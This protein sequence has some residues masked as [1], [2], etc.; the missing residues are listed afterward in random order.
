MPSKNALNLFAK[1]K[2]KKRKVKAQEWE[3]NLNLPNELIGTFNN[4]EE[5]FDF[6]KT[7]DPRYDEIEE[8][9]HGGKTHK[10]KIRQITKE[11]KDNWDY[12]LPYDYEIDIDDVIKRHGI[13]PDISTKR[14]WKR[15]KY[16]ASEMNIYLKKKKKYLAYKKKKDE[17][18]FRNKVS[19]MIL[20]YDIRLFINIDDVIDE[21]GLDY[22]L[23]VKENQKIILDRAKEHYEQYNVQEKKDERERIRK[24]RSEIMLKGR[25]RRLAWEESRPHTKDGKVILPHD[26]K[27]INWIKKD[28]KRKRKYVISKEKKWIPYTKANQ[29]KIDNDPQFAKKYQLKPKHKRSKRSYKTERKVKSINLKLKD[30]DKILTNLNGYL[31]TFVETY[32]ENT[33]RQD[34]THQLMSEIMGEMFYD[35]I[36]DKNKLENDEIFYEALRMFEAGEWQG[37]T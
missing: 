34:E 2:P 37:Y 14:N 36:N 30:P 35:L 13:D 15:L 8:I 32:E 27:W 20:P 11:I 5:Y 22:S 18:E 31:S 1:P 7:S 26:N 3:M 9:I 23:T 17:K 33:D 25:E 19:Q 12:R 28:P 10:Q 16:H 21:I 29:Y 4:E 6:L 24:I